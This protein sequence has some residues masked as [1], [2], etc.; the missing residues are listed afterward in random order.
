MSASEANTRTQLIDPALTLAGWNIKDP[1][2]VGLEI[3]VDGY[4]A[5]PW[6][7]VTD[8]CLYQPNGEVIAVVEAK[9]QSSDPQIAQTQVEYY[10]KEIEKHQSFRPFA[11]MTNGEETHFWD[12]GKSAKRQVAGFFSPS[13]LE[14]L[15]YI[16]QN[17]IALSSLPIN[18]QIAGRDYQQEAIR[19]VC[20][21]FDE[22]K[23]RTLLVMATGTGKT[24][25]A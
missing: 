9:R 5:E 12:V 14:N 4:N 6:N 22:G 2:Q 3:P 25:T 24:R 23:R 10:V 21:T 13:D 16:R 18:T 20:E 1:N 11:F 17:Q 19:R 8:Y 7:G 15:L